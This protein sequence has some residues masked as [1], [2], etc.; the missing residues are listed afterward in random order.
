MRFPQ[1]VI[2]DLLK[3]FGPGSVPHYFVMKTL[4]DLAMANPVGTVPMLQD[5]FSRTLPVLASIK[6]DNIRWVFA[7]A[8]GCFCE[9][10]L[11]YSINLGTAASTDITSFESPVSFLASFCWL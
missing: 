4:A 1:Q 11:S 2:T 5:I 9:A 10:I 6:Q 3:D 7:N 8:V